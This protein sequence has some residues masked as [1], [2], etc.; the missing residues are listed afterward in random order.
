LLERLILM[1]AAKIAGSV[2]VR[3]PALRQ[4][5]NTP[6]GSDRMMAGRLADTE[7]WAEAVEAS[8]LAH[9]ADVV[10]LLNNKFDAWPGII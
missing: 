4:A 1:E 9:E 3:L 5:L 6:R 2:A 7:G 10:L 8:A